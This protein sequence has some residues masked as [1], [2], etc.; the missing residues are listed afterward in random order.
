MTRINLG[1]LELEEGGWGPEEWDWRPEEWGGGLRGRTEGLGVAVA[2]RGLEPLGERDGRCP[3]IRR[4]KR[5]R[6]RKR[7]RKRRRKRK[8]KRKRKK[9]SWNRKKEEKII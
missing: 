3:K 8:R 9:K 2:Q 7:K 6:K 5:R 4:R 1:G